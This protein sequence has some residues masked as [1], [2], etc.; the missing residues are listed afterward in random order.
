MRE[1]CAGAPTGPPLLGSLWTG[2]APGDGRCCRADER[3]RRPP[4]LAHSAP[5]HV[6][7]V[8]RHFVD[9]ASLRTA[10]HAGYG[11]E[12]LLRGYVEIGGLRRD[13]VVRGA[14]RP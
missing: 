12:G 3:V 2:P 1:A 10:E 9:T 13:M 6:A 7:V 4:A 8:L 14:L 11:R 5:A